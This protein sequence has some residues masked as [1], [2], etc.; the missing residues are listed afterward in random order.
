MGKIRLYA[1]ILPGVVFGYFIFAASSSLN[2]FTPVRQLY[3][4]LGIAAGLFFGA[5]EARTIINELSGNSESIVWKPLPVGAVLVLLPLLLVL[6]FFGVSEYLPFGVYFIL[7]AIPVYLATSG[8]F[9]AKFEKDNRV[10]IFGSPFGFKYWTEPVEDVRTRFYHFVRDV[11]AKHP[12]ALWWHIG[13]AKKFMEILQE[14]QDVEPSTQKE[15]MDILKVMNRYRKLMLTVLVTVIGG[16]AILALFL[17]VVAAD[18]VKI[19]ASQFGNI[20]GPGS[21][22]LF[23]SAFAAVMLAMW[24]FKKTVRTRLAS[25]DSDKLSSL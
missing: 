1:S 16:G 4:F 15:L 6:G 20:V 7:S 10:N 22:I 21:G 8:W 3:L 23:F 14:K 25:I 19:P 9:Y 2:L 18:I 17:L 5:Y 12:S 24:K 13:G 11:V